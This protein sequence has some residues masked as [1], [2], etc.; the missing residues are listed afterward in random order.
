MNLCGFKS[1][2]LTM[3]VSNVSGALRQ[4]QST[5]KSY[6]R[7]LDH[8]LDITDGTPFTAIP[9]KVMR[10]YHDGLIPESKF[11]LLTMMLSHSD[12]FKIKRSYLVGRF[13]P[14]TLKRYLKELEDEGYIRREKVECATG[15]HEMI[16][17]TNRVNL[18]KIPVKTV[19]AIVEN[20]RQTVDAIVENGSLKNGS[21][22]NP[23][24]ETKKKKTKENEIQMD[25]CNNARD[26]ADTSNHPKIGFIDWVKRLENHFAPGFK[27]YDGN[28]AWFALQMQKHGLEGMQAF[29]LDIE[30]TVEKGRLYW[31]LK[32]RDWLFKDWEA[33]Q[34][35]ALRA[36][37]AQNRN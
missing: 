16:Y 36:E 28:N 8:L 11:K 20:P 33:R 31:T 29:V 5:T 26:K 35:E 14:N 21:L 34:S 15:G 1:K 32:N 25:G 10:A 9:Q 4:G 12:K 7:H 27:D 18:W 24:K 6:A 3:S 30:R 13:S 23:L 19:D 17:H 37:T 2:E 22:E